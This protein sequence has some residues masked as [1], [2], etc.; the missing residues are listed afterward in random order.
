MAEVKY[1]HT[2]I[3]SEDWEKLSKFYQIVFHCLPVPPERVQSGDW[4]EKGTGVKNASLKGIHLRLPGYGD[5]GPTLEIYEYE[6]MVKSVPATANR[7]GLGHLAFEIS[8]VK[9]T[10][11][12]IIDNGGR[13]IGEISEH[14]IS[15]VGKIEFVYAADPEGNIL[16]IQ[17]WT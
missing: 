7:K 8:D 11:D 10:L 17:R 14:F 9:S 6:E 15:G 2:N 1:V 16:E 3:V 13:A 4:L 5:S 12:L